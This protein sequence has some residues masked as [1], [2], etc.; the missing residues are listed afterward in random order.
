MDLGG[1]NRLVAWNALKVGRW[2]GEKGRSQS[3]ARQAGV[4]DLGAS[5]ARRVEPQLPLYLILLGSSW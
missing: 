1:E 3:E 5:T 2:V 4:Q